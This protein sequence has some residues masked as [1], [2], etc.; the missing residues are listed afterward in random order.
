M[1]GL[2]WLE[3]VY[4]SVSHC[5]ATRGKQIEVGD[6]VRF[7]IEGDE[8]SCV[9][10]LGGKQRFKFESLRRLPIKLLGGTWDRR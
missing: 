1:G 10:S 8:A 2:G 4:L 7:K 3:I 9:F 6:V 5:C